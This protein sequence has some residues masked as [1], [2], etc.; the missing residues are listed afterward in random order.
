MEREERR[1]K[2]KAERR[3]SADLHTDLESGGALWVGRALWF[4]VCAWDS[5]VWVV[6]DLKKDPRNICAFIVLFDLCVACSCLLCA[7]CVLNNSYK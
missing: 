3:G 6:S 7:S 1:Q 4:L 2:Q 5:V